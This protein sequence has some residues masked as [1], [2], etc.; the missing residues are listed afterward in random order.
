MAKTAAQPKPAAAKPA[1][2]TKAIQKQPKN[3]KARFDLSELREGH[4]LSYVSYYRVASTAN[5]SGE[6]F[7]NDQNGDSKMVSSSILEKWPSADHYAKEVPM[8]MTS[9]AELLETFS[10]TVFT[11]C[12]H[13]QPTVDGAVD[14]LN[15]ESLASAKKDAAKLAKMLTEG[16][17]CT[18]ICHL[19]KVENN[20]GRST[21]IDL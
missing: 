9:L 5:K 20:L 10:D 16:E 11:V 1:P 15:A 18:M 21:V 8:T 7:V 12:F 13:K 6:V 3:A 4:Q 2:K 19:V 17:L 14:K